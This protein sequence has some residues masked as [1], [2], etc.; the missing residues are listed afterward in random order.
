[1]LTYTFLNKTPFFNYHA[2]AVWVAYDIM[3]NYKMK[4]FKTKTFYFQIIKLE[5]TEC[6]LINILTTFIYIGKS[7]LPCFLEAFLR[8]EI[9]KK[10][11][12]FN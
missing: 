3:K 9:T 1:M 7:C 4:N 8:N 10:S 2:K 11:L 6:Q 12:H 5:N